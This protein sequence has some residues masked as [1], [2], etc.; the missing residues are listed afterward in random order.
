MLKEML[1][2]YNA[3]RTEWEYE[4][5]LLVYASDFL[6]AFGNGQIKISAQSYQELYNYCI[7]NYKDKIPKEYQE[8]SGVFPIEIKS[9]DDILNAPAYTLKTDGFTRKGGFVISAGKALNTE[10][11]KELRD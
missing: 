1:K 8:E 5:L 2:A 6:Q 3:R 7:T 4:T 11:V 9:P 10:K